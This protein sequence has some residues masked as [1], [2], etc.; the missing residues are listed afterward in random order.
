MSVQRLRYI[1]ALGKH[2]NFK[3]AAA[4]L[5]ISQPAL[6]KALKQMEDHYGVI[7]FDRSTRQV[8]PTEF[9]MILIQAADQI[10]MQFSEIE[11]E[12]ELLKGFERGSLVIG[13]NPY[14]AD[15]VLVNALREM[16]NEHPRLRYKIVTAMPEEL[17]PQLLDKQVDVVVGTH[18]DQG[19]LPNV[20]YNIYKFPE[21]VSFCSP[22]HPLAKQKEVNVLDAFNYPIVGVM[23]PKY[24]QD[25]LIEQTGMSTDDE[26]VSSP[27]VAVCDTF[28]MILELVK[29]G[30]SLS[31]GPRE[32]LQEHID[33]GDIMELKLNAEPVPQSQ[34]GV[35][36]LKGRMMPPALAG[37]LKSL[38]NE[39]T[40]RK[41]SLKN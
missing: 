8:R 26:R 41:K 3:H 6:S 21:L 20:D 5:G 13:C 36:V 24:I 11:R 18:M 33:K 22:K 30:E 28:S 17:M 29:T 4:S 40:R 19:E 16:L 39:M 35:A 7:L 31:I 34:F 38:H 2:R 23:A 27:V 12:I 14:L 25:W 15:T 32:V 37:F 10:V 9:G 1:Q